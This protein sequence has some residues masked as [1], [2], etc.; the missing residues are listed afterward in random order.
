M[1]QTNK[2][3][4]QQEQQPNPPTDPIDQV[5]DTITGEE[6]TVRSKVVVNATGVFADG[7]RKMDDPDA[8]ELIEPAA[9][10]LGW[11]MDGWLG[12]YIMCWI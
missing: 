8:V 5:K 11:V 12:M 9:G 2:I 7:I 6:W 10:G 3:P 1:P 4:P